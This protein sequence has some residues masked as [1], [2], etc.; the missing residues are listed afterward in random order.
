MGNGLITSEFYKGSKDNPLSEYYSVK[1]RIAA[2]QGQAPNEVYYV[3]IAA[4]PDTRSPSRDTHVVEWLP[5]AG[6]LKRMKATK[7]LPVS[8]S[9]V[10]GIGFLRPKIQIDD[11]LMDPT[12]TM[13]TDGEPPSGPGRHTIIAGRRSRNPD[14]RTGIDFDLIS[15]S[16]TMK[17]PGGTA[18]KLTEKNIHMTKPTTTLEMNDRGWQTENFLADFLPSFPTFPIGMQRLPNLPLMAKMF[19]TISLVIAAI[20]TIKKLLK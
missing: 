14:D 8:V 18:I 19:G 3:W 7:N 12:T 16:T 10:D 6:N 17:G 20:L 4:K 1:T 11:F 13:I 15:G 5:R 2:V 9:R